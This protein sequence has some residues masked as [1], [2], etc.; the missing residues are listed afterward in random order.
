V[1]PGHSLSLCV[2]QAVHKTCCSSTAHR[3]LSTAN[4]AHPHT[5]ERQRSLLCSAQRMT[6]VTST[7]ERC[8]PHLLRSSDSSC[9]VSLS[10][11]HSACWQLLVSCWSVVGQLLVSCCSDSSVVSLSRVHSACTIGLEGAGGA[12]GGGGRGTCNREVKL[13]HFA[14]SGPSLLPQLSDSLVEQL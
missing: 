6:S 10:R 13:L 8:M 5:D 7:F 1:G 9:V 4:I 2:D 11:V 14:V 3:R 12:V